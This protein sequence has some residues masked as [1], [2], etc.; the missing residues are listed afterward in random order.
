MMMIH[1]PKICRHYEY[2]TDAFMVSCMESEISNYSFLVDLEIS[3]V[4]AYY[5]RIL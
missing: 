3:H 2:L 1:H 5:S 4:G